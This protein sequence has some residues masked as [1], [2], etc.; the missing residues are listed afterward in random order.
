M[1]HP[2]HPYRP[3]LLVETTED[4]L[5]ELRTHIPYGMR[6][7]LFEAIVKDLVSMISAEGESIV[8]HI[9]SGSIRFGRR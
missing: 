6:R 4:N 3:R 2:K 8:F 7:P 1:K 5:A 9:I